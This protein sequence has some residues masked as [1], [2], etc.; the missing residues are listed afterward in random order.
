MVIRK[1][2]YN[3]HCKTFPHCTREM[4]ISQ[5]LL[6][7]MLK[8]NDLAV[9]LFPDLYYLVYVCTYVYHRYACT[10]LRICINMFS[11]LFLVSTMNTSLCLSPILRFN[12]TYWIYLQSLCYSMVSWR[13]LRIDIYV[14]IIET[15]LLCNWLVPCFWIEM[16]FSRHSYFL[17]IFS[18]SVWKWHAIFMHSIYDIEENEVS[19]EK[20]CYIICY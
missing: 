11:L 17:F 20:L 8:I 14:F 7:C 15:M 2:K 10:R 18:A 19:Q 1:G 5:K 6:F 3:V 4:N 12:N 9:K 13:G 16:D